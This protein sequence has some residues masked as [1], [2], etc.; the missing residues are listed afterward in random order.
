MPLKH[1]MIYAKPQSGSP[2]N[3]P[4]NPIIQPKLLQP[5]DPHPYPNT[6]RKLQFQ[7]F[8]E[9]HNNLLLLIKPWDATG[10]DD[11]APKASPKRGPGLYLQGCRE[12]YNK[13]YYSIFD[14]A[15]PGVYCR[16]LGLYVLSSQ[17]FLGL[18][19]GV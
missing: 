8:L 10:V 4:E 5:Q 12:F 17:R 3:A 13:V 14:M 15:L 16:G 2:N 11:V 9:R 7:E 19:V 1:S 18:K 6:P